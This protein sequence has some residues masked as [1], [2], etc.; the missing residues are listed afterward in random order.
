MKQAPKAFEGVDRAKNLTAAALNLFAGRGFASV[1]IK[2]IAK[3]TKV[4]TALI[5]YYFEDKA[6]LFR[7][8]IGHAV[9]QALQNYRRLRHE[10]TNPALLLDDWFDTNVQLSNDIRKL[11]KIMLDYSGSSS[12]SSSIDRQIKLFYTEELRILSS[13]IR[14]GIA[15]GLFRSVDERGL[16][17]FVSTHP[18]GVMVASMIRA[19]FDIKA[20]INDLRK[21]L[22]HYLE[23]RS[24]ARAKTKAVA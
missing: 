24:D 14:D 15:Q 7:M 13:S 8:T 20:A 16:A 22:W 4:N 10:H 17:L 3:A 21:Q 19:D 1:T 23:Y 2:D 5:Y 12:G 9:T 18:D 6:D 11:V